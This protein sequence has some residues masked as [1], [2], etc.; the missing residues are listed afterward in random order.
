MQRDAGQE[1]GRTSTTD[2]SAASACTDNGAITKCTLH[3]SV[4]WGKEHCAR[5]SDPAQRLK[6]ADI[7]YSTVDGQSKKIRDNVQTVRE[8][9]VA[10]D[11]GDEAGT[12]TKHGN[13]I[14]RA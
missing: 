10:L 11:F 4:L 9:A 2:I 6:L 8:N 3:P 14:R 7:S 5:C 1:E 13:G 12:R